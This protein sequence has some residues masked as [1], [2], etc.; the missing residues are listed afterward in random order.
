LTR[1]RRRIGKPW[2]QD[3][4]IALERR[5]D[6]PGFGPWSLKGG[7]V[8]VEPAVEVLE[9]MLALR[10]HLDDCDE[11]NGPLR[12]IP[13]SQVLGRL[14]AIEIRRRC[15]RAP[16]VACLVPAGGVVLMRPLLLNASSIAAGASVI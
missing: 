14:T 7:I 16:S 15:K 8:H 2:H 4:T 10:L 5:V 9:H 3:R 13:G 1:R 12:V 11:A 6:C